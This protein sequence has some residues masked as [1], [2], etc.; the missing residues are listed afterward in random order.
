MPTNLRP[1]DKLRKKMQESYEEEEEDVDLILGQKDYTEADVKELQVRNKILLEALRKVKLLVERLLIQNRELKRRVE[2]LEVEFN[3]QT[4]KGVQMVSVARYKEMQSNATELARS[5][6][7][8]IKLIKLLNK[9]N[10]LVKDKYSALENEF[11]D[12]IDERDDLKQTIFQ[13]NETN[14]EQVITELTELF[15]TDVIAAKVS[16]A[17]SS[18]VEAAII[19]NNIDPE[20]KT[21][22]SATSVSVPSF[23]DQAR[24]DLDQVAGFNNNQVS[25]LVD[26]VMEI[27]HKIENLSGTMVVPA[28]VRKRGKADLNLTDAIEES[29]MADLDDPPDRPDL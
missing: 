19:N 29:E 9:E 4:K 26:L 28:S 21:I 20:A 24:T 10:K 17:I 16:D 22:A 2:I 1:E 13:L 5:L 11:E 3:E 25:M 8:L 7:K 18:P 27:K 15:P 23:E 12:L 6:P 14:Q